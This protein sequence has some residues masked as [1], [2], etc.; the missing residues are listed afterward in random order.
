M[1]FL[2]QPFTFAAWTSDDNNHWHAATCEHAGEQGNKAPHEW[3]EG[4]IITPAG[5]T[6][7]GEKEYTCTVCGRTKTETLPAAGHTYS[8]E[9]SYD[10]AYHWHAATCEHTD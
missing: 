10:G 3:D 1:L 9:W 2:Y 6:Q 5:C 7:A 8:D 4:E